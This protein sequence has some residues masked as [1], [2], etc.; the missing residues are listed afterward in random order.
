MQCEK[1]HT[2]CDEKKLA[3]S[4][5]VHRGD[6]CKYKPLKT[7]TFEASVAATQPRHQCLTPLDQHQLALDIRDFCATLFLGENERIS[8]ICGLTEAHPVR[9]MLPYFSRISR[10]SPTYSCMVS[11]GLHIFRISTQ[12][13]SVDTH[14]IEAKGLALR[15]LR[16]ALGSGLHSK[17]ELL[18]SV[19]LLTWHECISP[20]DTGISL[21]Q[22]LALEALVFG[23]DSA[24]LEMPDH[25][26]LIGSIHTLCGFFKMSLADW[27]TYESESSSSTAARDAI[28]AGVTDYR[29]LLTALAAEGASL[30][31]KTKRLCM[32]SSARDTCSRALADGL[33][34][35]AHRLLSNSNNFFE[36]LCESD[37]PKVYRICP[38]FRGSLDVSQQPFRADYAYQFPSA[39]LGATFILWHLGRVYLLLVAVHCIHFQNEHRQLST[40][41]A[42]LLKLFEDIRQE[43]NEI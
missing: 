28:A 29:I 25:R 19:L 9:A 17:I 1:V 8:P 43:A 20:P 18:I 14:V 16:A 35:D 22:I 23:L 24:D 15:S 39:D 37:R 31:A 21:K 40:K 4:R 32:E 27:V 6:A 33:S 30:R 12:N 3:C 13:V 10:D 11:Y 41:D 34:G 2:K 26:Y 38:S 7:W 36:L 5:C 42:K